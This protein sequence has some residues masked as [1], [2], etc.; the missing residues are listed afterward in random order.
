MKEE[1]LK[2]LQLKALDQFK[3]GKSLFGKDCAFAPLLKQFLDAAL[4]VEMEEHLDESERGRGNKR[5]GKGKKTVKSSSGSFEIETPQDRLS[6]F[7]PDI[8]KKRET[9][10][11]ESLEEK[12]F[13]MYGMGMSMRD[14]RAHIADMYDTQISH[15]VISEIT[16]RIIPTV[17]EWQN[18]PLEG[19]YCIVCI[20]R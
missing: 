13:G 9:I 1:E 8:I 11:A 12:I 2:Q 20:T 7:T 15:T 16:D 4:E 5:N 17:K 14:I 18:P 10:L 6:S 3:S 19:L